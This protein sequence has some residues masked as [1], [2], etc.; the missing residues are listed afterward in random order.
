MSPHRTATTR[1]ALLTLVVMGLALV[2]C[3]APRSPGP[4]A[5]WPV[6]R[7]LGWWLDVYEASRAEE[8]GAP[9]DTWDRSL[10]VR[11][12]IKQEYS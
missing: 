1:R 7:Q 6:D 8:A 10:R 11:C 12:M 2:A 9:A 5:D 3:S 4:P